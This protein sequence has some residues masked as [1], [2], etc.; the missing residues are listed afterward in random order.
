MSEPVLGVLML[1]T[2]F[3]RPP[4]DIGNPASFTHRVIYRTLP[5]AIVSTIVT[6]QPLPD[7]LVSQFVNE[8]KAL[9]RAGATI[10]TTSC[11]FL[12]PLQHHLQDAVE[13][14][15]ITSSLWL[16]PHVRNL[17]GHDATI[18]IATFDAASLSAHHIPDEGPVVVE[19]LKPEDHL[20]Q[21][22]KNNLPHLDQHKAQDDFDRLI[23]RLF[24]RKADIS[25]LIIE[26]TNMPPYIDKHLKSLAIPIYDILDGIKHL[27]N[28][29]KMHVN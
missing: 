8:A 6:D 9:E 28:V 21:V 15:V 19:G 17:I 25:A 10:I 3:P 23:E 14:P 16:I 13:V 12:S 1:E 2:G 24:A 5:G 20:F 4:G 11:G 29:D 18:G 7:V 22:I 27:Q 26:C